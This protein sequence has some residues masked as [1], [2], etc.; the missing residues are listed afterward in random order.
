VKQSHRMTH[1]EKP[2]TKG[3]RTQV[4]RSSHREHSVPIFETSGFIFDSAEQAR[5]VFADEQAGNIYSRFSNPNTDEFIE[6]LCLLEEAEDGVPASSGMAAIYL[7]MTA[8]LQPGDHILAGRQL[9]GTTH[10]LITQVLSRW[11]ISHTYVD[12]KNSKEWEAA[13]LPTTRLIFVESPSNPLLELADLKWLGKFSAKN[14][15]YFLIDNSFATP[16]LQNPI[17]FGA[18]LI[19]HSATKFLDGQGRTISGAVVGSKEIIREVRTLA[20][21]TGPVLSPFTG[22]LLSKSLETL[23][24][25]MEKHCQN[26]LRLARFLEGHPDISHVNYP[27]LP[28]HPQ[29]RLAK[30]QMKA[31]GG[32]VAFELKGGLNRVKRFIDSLELMSISPNLGDTRTI[33]THPATTTHVKLSDAEK[34]ESGIT[35]GLIRISVGLEDIEDLTADIGRALDHSN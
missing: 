23:P 28:S 34:K 5:A 12:M 2:E 13:L 17:R 19:I 20:R 14:D 22:W 4:K 21:I 30:R 26:A 15:L 1:K 11:G 8:L 35:N 18:D 10:L 29:Y 32:L 6:K 16:Y 31:G 33:I 7:A 3:I 24:V 9:F 27:F 25:R